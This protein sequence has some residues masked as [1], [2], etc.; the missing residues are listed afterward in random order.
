M[1]DDVCCVLCVVCCVLCVCAG[2]CVRAC[3]GGRVWGVCGRVGVRV[4][5]YEEEEEEICLFNI[6]CSYTNSAM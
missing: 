6:V 4:S 3:G 1:F 2:G 5:M